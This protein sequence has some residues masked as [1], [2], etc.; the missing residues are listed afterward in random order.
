MK[1]LRRFVRRLAASVVGQRDDRVREELAE[2]LTLLTEE[3]TRA[4]LSPAEA[5]RQARLRLGS[6]DATT[7]AYR[8]TQRLRP[9]EH[10]W[11]DLDYAVRTLRGSPTFATT[12]IVTFALG[13]GANTAIFSRFE[14][15]MLR[16]DPIQAADD[17]YFVGHG[18]PRSA[19][20]SNYPY[21]ERVRARTD[22]FTGV[23]AYLK[24]GTV[25]VSNAETTETARAQFVSGNY[26]TVV[27]VP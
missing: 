24:S 8:D 27:G 26:H 7:E 6:L 3:Y 5:H 22:L 15:I 14:A 2:H 16:L 12:V 18:S 19:P 9:L 17:L 4:G 23:T 13:I 10:S 25:K 11:Q 1:A 20:S 21:F